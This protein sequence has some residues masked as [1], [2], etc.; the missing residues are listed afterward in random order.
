M[1]QNGELILFPIG[2]GVIFYAIEKALKSHG[3]HLSATVGIESGPGLIPFIADFFLIGVALILIFMAII[4]IG[5]VFK[6]LF[7]RRGHN[8]KSD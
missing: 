7:C 6:F 5:R 1:D 3:W 2:V 8:E 4:G